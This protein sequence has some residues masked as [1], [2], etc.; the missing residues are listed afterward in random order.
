[1]VVD[2]HGSGAIDIR[3]LHPAARLFCGRPMGYPFGCT[4]E[5][6]VAMNIGQHA[7]ANT[8]GGHLSHTGSFS[9]ENLTINGVS[10][11]ELGKNMLFAAYFASPRSRLPAT[12]Q[13][14]EAKAL[15]PEIE[16]A[17]VWVGWKGAGYE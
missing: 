16:T 8:D 17:A 9:V 4:D 5:F 1:M 6:D 15:G 12:W 7:K 2:G 3:L 11:G 13:C 10:L 14:E